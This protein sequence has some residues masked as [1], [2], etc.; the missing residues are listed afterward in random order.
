MDL[1][2]WGGHGDVLFQQHD[3]KTGAVTAGRGQVRTL[4]YQCFRPIKGLE[5]RAC[6]LS[7][8]MIFYSVLI[9]LHFGFG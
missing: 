3:W 2:R 7:V 4:R 1:L 6:K 9:E 8:G 5:I